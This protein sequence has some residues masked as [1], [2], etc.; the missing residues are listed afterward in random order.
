MQRYNQRVRE[1]LDD[2]LD[3]VPEQLLHVA[4]EHR[5]MHAETFAYILH[6]LPYERKTGPAART[7]TVRSWSRSRSMITIPAGPRGSGSRAER[8][9]AGTTNSRPTSWTCPFAIAQDKVTN[10]EYLEFVREGA[11]PPFFWARARRPLGLPRH[12]GGSSPAARRAGVRHP[13]RGLRL[14]AL[15]RQRLPT[16]PEFHRAAE[17]ARPGQCRFPLLGPGPGHRG[18]RP[19]RPCQMVGNGWE[20]TSTVFAPVP[21]LRAV[22]VLPE[23]F[24][25]VLRRPALCVEG[26]FAADRRLFSAA[27]VPQLVPPVVS[28]HL[29]RLPVGGPLNV[30]SSAGHRIRP[31]RAAG[32]DAPDQKTLPCRYLYDDVGSAL[33]DAIT[34]LPEYGLTRADARVI[35]AA[36]GGPGQ[37]L[38][39][40]VIIAELGSG[41]GAKTRPILEAWTERQMVVY[42]PSTSPPP[43]SPS[44]RRISSR[45][46]HVVPLEV[47]YLDGLRESPTAARPAR[48]CWC[49]SSA[50]PSATSSP[51]R[52]SISCLPSASCPA[53]RRRA[54][55]GHGPGQADR[56]LLDAYDDPTGVTA[57]FNLNLL[58]RINREL[59]ADFDLRQFEHVI[60]YNEE[61]QRIEMH[62]RSS[63]TRSSASTRRT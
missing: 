62:L 33:F 40:N 16:E 7:R 30:R 17:G 5:L 37:L 27:V 39:A 22:S 21:R 46:A 61:A 19:G 6:Q 38:P 63:A 35:A 4:I 36:R 32:L 18:R 50:A 56:E 28:L 49:C 31:R 43:R 15:A 29:R 47:S 11:A 9:S 3:D 23:L 1:E 12:V 41:S 42:Y 51:R 14:R 58:G 34:Y 10:G 55:A 20:W 54:A 13:R 48:R 44:A 45:S 26:R 53:A 59:E 60:R 52:R 24:G 25:A 2:A 57:A 8:A